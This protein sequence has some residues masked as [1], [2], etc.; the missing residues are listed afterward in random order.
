MYM[1]TCLWWAEYLSLYSDW[2]RVGR[3]RDQ[4]PVGARF[5]A[6]IQTTLGPT[7]PPV[8]WVPGLSW[9]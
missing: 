3:S 2:L 9:G 4:I 1:S 6:H 7:Q 8:Q 5:F